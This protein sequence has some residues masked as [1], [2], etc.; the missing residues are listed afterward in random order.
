MRRITC[1]NTANN[2]SVIF[3][4]AF[5]PFLLSDAEGIYTVDIT[6]NSVENSMLDGST[7]AG[8]VVRARNIV[9][10]IVD[11]EDYGSNRN[12][13]YSLFMPRTEGS[14]VYEEIDG[15]FSE[16][17]MINYVVEKIE[18]GSSGEARFHTVSLICPDP[19]F[20]DLSD[21]YVQMIGWEGAFEFDHEFSDDGEEISYRVQNKLVEIAN[22]SSVDDL[23]FVATLIAEGN[24]TNPKLYLLERDEYIQIGSDNYPFN[25]VYGDRLIISTVTARKN[26]ILVRDGVQSYANQYIEE[27]SEYIQLKIGVNTIRLSA[28]SGEDNL[29]AAISFRNK[30]Q[31]V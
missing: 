29:L 17:R 19:F 16:K 21:T 26:V 20:T 2:I 18:P 27:G 14:L 23:G 15:S 4:D 5:S 9:L 7:I 31:G 6:V 30:Y 10:T 3:G 8:S 1:T 22:E 13:L 25:M 11:K 28:E 12:L 24:V